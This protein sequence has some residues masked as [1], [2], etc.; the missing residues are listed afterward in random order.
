MSDQINHYRRRFLGTVAIRVVAASGI[1]AS[2]LASVISCP[3]K[4]Q[5]LSSAVT[6]H[7]DT[8]EGR[9]GCTNRK[10]LDAGCAARASPL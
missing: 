9:Y 1:T 7:I 3:R 10:P 5:S 8:N 6:A 4:P 2:S